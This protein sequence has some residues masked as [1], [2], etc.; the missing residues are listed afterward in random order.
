MTPSHSS[1]LHHHVPGSGHHISH[2]QY[3]QREQPPILS[4]VRYENN[5]KMRYLPIM[6]C[7][8]SLYTLYYIFLFS[9]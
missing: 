8:R 3:I 6:D 2:L 5:G 4:Y 9:P 1:H 7:R